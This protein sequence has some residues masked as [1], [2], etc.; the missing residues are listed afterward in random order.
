MQTIKRIGID[1]GG[2]KTSAVLLNAE[3]REI[4]RHRVSSPQN[5]YDATVKNIA[6]LIATVKAEVREP[7]DFF[8]GMGI[9]GTIDPITK[10]VKNANS[11]WLNHKPLKE[12]LEAAVGQEV[13]IE[14]D[15]N[16]FAVSEAV[17]GV[18][19]GYGIVWG[20]ILGTGCG[21]GIVIN[22]QTLSGASGIGGEWGHNPLPSP[23]G[24]DEIPGPACYCGRTGCLETYI[25]GTGFEKDYER[26][27]GT[28]IKSIEVMK[29][30]R[31]GDP[32]AIASFDRYLDRL[33]R[34]IGAGINILDPH[35]IVLGG[36]M[37][38]IDELYDRLPNLLMGIDAG[39]ATHKDKQHVFDTSPQPIMRAKIL[40]P[41]HGDDS[42]V[43]G[44]AY[45]WTAQTI[46]ERLAR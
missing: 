13:K 30:A 4:F 33:A 2:T 42:G 38:N 7:A 18:A 25:S 16:C 24:N 29:L 41:T 39:G 9:P 44:A 35:A 45:L 43:R 1:L 3:G 12:D 11:I 22:Q 19:K 46:Q 28:R 5:D 10:R 26:A 17:D 23:R 34:G 37:G 20:L 40:R 32:V 6:T 14:N 36:G 27:T 8:I 15:A 31:T 21:S